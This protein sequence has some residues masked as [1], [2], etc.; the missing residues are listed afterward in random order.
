M[1]EIPPGKIK[2]AT[3]S[4]PGSKSFSHRILIAAALSDGLCK[5]ENVLE[6]EDTLHTINCL[7]RL[8]V[9]I[10]ETGPGYDIQGRSGGLEAVADPIELGNS[11]T[12]MRLLTAVAALGKGSYILTGTPRM[13]QRPIQDL[14]NGLN[15]LGISAKAIHNNGCPPVEI[16][17]GEIN[18]GSVAIDCHIS[19]QFLSALLLIAPF[20]RDE[21]RIAV[22]RGPVSKPYVDLTVQVMERFGIKL[23]R[24]GYESFKV[25]GGQQYRSG[26]YFVEPDSSQAGYFWAAAAVT[27]ATI[28]VNGTSLDSRQGD[29]RFT[30]VLEQMGCE[31]CSDSDGIT[32]KGRPLQGITVD[33]ADMPDM[34]PTLAVVAAFAKGTTT[35]NN[36]AHL[37][38]KESDRL[39]AVATNLLKMGINA[40]C[41]DSGLIIEGGKPHG[42]EIETYDDH[43]IAMCFAV[44]GLVV[45]GIKIKDE[46]CVAKSFPNFW[47][48]FQQL[49][50]D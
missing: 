48:V 5:I 12:S 39:S 11:G 32:V 23:E 19:S 31:L 37:K 2:N 29:T 44:A 20:A 14:L 45:E 26:S 25:P 38:E 41:T 35:I 18:G 50:S 8:G 9:A 47:E 40:S 27:G 21:V 28:K 4:V 46:N 15:Q 22:S 13:Q 36:V 34:V 7:R 42:A 24:E 33:M 10:E 49:Y 6:S 16:S 43:R 3:V 1:I 17:G 30:K